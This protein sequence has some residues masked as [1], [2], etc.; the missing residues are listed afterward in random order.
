ML[1]ISRVITALWRSGLAREAHNLEVP[2]SKRGS[3]MM[4]ANLIGIFRSRISCITVH[5]NDTFFM[6]TIAGHGLLLIE[7]FDLFPICAF[8]HMI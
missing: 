4:Y 2:R 6:N 3:A 5:C 7:R 8:Y 1:S